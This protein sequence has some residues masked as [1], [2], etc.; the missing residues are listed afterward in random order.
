M[1]MTVETTVTD[2][3]VITRFSMADDPLG[4]IEMVF[5]ELNSLMWRI[6]FMGTTINIPR[7]G[8][9]IFHRALGHVLSLRK[10]NHHFAKGD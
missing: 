5:E 3:S 8:I 10:T 9:A 6:E 7:D 2:T 1:A 4:D